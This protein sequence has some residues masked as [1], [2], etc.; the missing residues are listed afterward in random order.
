[1]TKP[2]NNSL[3]Y[4]VDNFQNLSID[5]KKVIDLIPYIVRS[6]ERM[7]LNEAS[8]FIKPFFRP[9]KK[10]RFTKLCDSFFDN[11]LVVSFQEFSDFLHHDNEKA[12]LII[13]SLLFQFNG[14]YPKSP[15]E[16]DFI[17]RN[18]QNFRGISKYS[19]NKKRLPSNKMI[20]D[21]TSWLI[22]V[23]VATILTGDADI[24]IVISTS[25][26]SNIASYD[27]KAILRQLFYNEKPDPAKRE[28]FIQMLN[29][30]IKNL[31]TKIS[32]IYK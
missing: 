7:V 27:A 8:Y 1:M 29:K 14:T 10:R 19:I 32:S 11:L 16:N 26:V 18:T 24:A 4:L 31:T 28:E 13:D 17:Y 3:K 21:S 15:K 25:T 6:F 30:N 12:S 20:S 2:N 23:E 22:G 5:E 9:F